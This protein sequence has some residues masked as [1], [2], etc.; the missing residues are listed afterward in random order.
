MYDRSVR[1]HVG[2]VS[3]PPTQCLTV[4]DVG[5]DDEDEHYSLYAR[6]EVAVLLPG[7]ARGFFFLRLFSIDAMLNASMEV[8][9][10]SAGAIGVIV[11]VSLP[12]VFCCAGC[13]ADKFNLVAVGLQAEPVQ[14]VLAA[15]ARA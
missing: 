8:A 7:C 6:M 11:V 9:V 1:E 13:F 15:R 4:L 12:T 14:S 3:A 2:S 5:T 10:L